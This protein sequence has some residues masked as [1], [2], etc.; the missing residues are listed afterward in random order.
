VIE[1]LTPKSSKSNSNKKKKKKF[2]PK[3]NLKDPK[4][5]KKSTEGCESAKQISF[6][7]ESCND[8]FDTFPSL[9]E[10]LAIHLE[11]QP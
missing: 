8:T 2:V 5:K 10:H 7:C 1:T 9:N 11:G 6:E 3:L 4:P